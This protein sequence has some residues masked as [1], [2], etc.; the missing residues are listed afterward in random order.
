MSESFTK[1][2]ASITASTIWQEPAGTRLV[3]I[4]MLAMAGRDGVVRGSVPGLAS[5]AKVTLAETE[6]A[7]TCFLSPDKYSRTKDHEGRR[8]AEVDGGWLLLNHAKFRGVT[9]DEKRKIWA[10]EKK[11]QRAAKK[12]GG[13]ARAN[14]KNVRDMSGT[15]QDMSRMSA[16]SGATE[17]DADADADQKQDQELEA[18]AERSRDRSTPALDDDGREFIRLPLKSGAEY[19]VLRRYVREM[20]ELF[21]AVDIEQQFREMRGWCLA[22]PTKRKTAAGIRKFVNS[23][24]AKEQDGSGTFPDGTPIRQG[25]FAALRRESA[26]GRSE[27]LAREGD[28]RDRLQ[29][30]TGRKLSAVEQVEFEI[31]SRRRRE[32][33]REAAM[34][35]RASGL[36]VVDVAARK[37]QRIAER[38]GLCLD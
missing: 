2:C 29:E 3:W 37:L 34:Q 7:L 16:M 36:G 26:A 31:L 11:A 12:S 15:V 4:T 18:C 9:I 5:L 25:G 27:R 23:W 13:K 1:L 28:E 10:E 8:I 33:E 14:K 22:N 32:T 24:L 21:P 17:A 6:I 30:L 20:A 35:D 19:S 38:T